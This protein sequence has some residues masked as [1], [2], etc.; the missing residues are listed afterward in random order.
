MSLSLL[1]IADDAERRA[2]LRSLRLGV[3][4]IC[5]GRA[6]ELERALAAGRAR[7]AGDTPRRALA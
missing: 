5:G 3:R 7:P 2:R 4:V 1:D 6:P